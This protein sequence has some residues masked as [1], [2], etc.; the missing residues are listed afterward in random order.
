[1]LSENNLVKMH[2]HWENLCDQE[3]RDL[4]QLQTKDPKGFLANTGACE[5]GMEQ[6]FH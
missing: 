5:K 3:G 4:R 2:T 6:I 1:M